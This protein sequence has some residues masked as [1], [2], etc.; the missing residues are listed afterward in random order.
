VGDKGAAV[1]AARVPKAGEVWT[2]DW[3]K[4]ATMIRTRED[5]AWLL[6]YP[7]G[8]RSWWPL[9]I[10][11]ERWTPPARVLPDCER[12]R[13][14]YENGTLGQGCLTRNV[15]DTLQE[16]DRIAVLHYGVKNG[17][18]FAEVEEVEG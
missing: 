2:G 3:V 4:P 15:A 10:I 5:G 12:W 13:N 7:D 11:Q 9:D 14:L 8:E 1:K 18:P 16:D 6:E 17:Q